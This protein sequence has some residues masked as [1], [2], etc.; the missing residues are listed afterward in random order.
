MRE[1]GGLYF[2]QHKTLQ[3]PIVKNKVDG[4]FISLNVDSLLSCHK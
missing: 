2:K 4:K 3:Q 1:F